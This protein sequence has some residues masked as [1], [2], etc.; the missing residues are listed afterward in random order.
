VVIPAVLWLVAF[1]RA[2][3]RLKPWLS[4][5]SMFSS[6]SRVARFAGFSAIIGVAVEFHCLLGWVDCGFITQISDYCVKRYAVEP[7]H[8]SHTV[9]PGAVL[10]CGTGD[11]SVGILDLAN[12]PPILD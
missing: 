11:E 3:A 12:L 2:F 10:V 1:V 5:F 9:C 4:K 7:H 6:A 8:R